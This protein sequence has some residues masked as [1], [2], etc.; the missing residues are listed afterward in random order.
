MC[1]IESVY[2]CDRVLLVNCCNHLK[3]IDRGLSDKELFNLAQKYRLR[4]L[5]ANLEVKMLPGEYFLVWCI[6]DVTLKLVIC[7][8][9][10]SHIR[11]I[12]N[13][14]NKDSQPHLAKSILNLAKLTCG[15]KTEMPIVLDFPTDI[16]SL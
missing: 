15:L 2:L 13:F 1:L 9:K 3:P 11:Q 10:C 16:F 14:Q 12:V 8:L 4:I 5:N 7:Y 6:L